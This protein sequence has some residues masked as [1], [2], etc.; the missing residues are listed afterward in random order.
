MFD[1]R[2]LHHAHPRWSPSPQY[3][4]TKHHKHHQLPDRDCRYHSRH[5]NTLSRTAP[6]VRHF[7]SYSGPY[8]ILSQPSAAL[9][10]LSISKHNSF[11]PH[12]ISS[13][14][15]LHKVTGRSPKPALPT[16]F[17]TICTLHFVTFWSLLLFVVG[18]IYIALYFPC[19]CVP[20][21]LNVSSLV[22]G[23]P[24]ALYCLP[25]KSVLSPCLCFLGCPCN[26]FVPVL[27]CYIGECVELSCVLSLTCVVLHLPC[28]CESSFVTFSF[29]Q[30]N[31]QLQLQELPLFRLVKLPLFGLVKL[32]LFGLL[33][34]DYTLFVD[35][36]LRCEDVAFQRHADLS[37]RGLT[38]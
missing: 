9:P 35:T 24:C 38:C 16:T 32:P 23:I 17:S 19:L 5:P 22:L 6:P 18:L 33:T 21:F 1:R 31:T 2:K 34:S 12:L 37:C 20:C 4:G 8:F 14:T 36:W 15:S 26:V 3:V 30:P 10:L 13:G 7:T 25:C 11:R 27:V 29:S 28:L